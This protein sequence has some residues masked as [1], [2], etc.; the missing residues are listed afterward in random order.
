MHLNS[1]CLPHKG[2]KSLMNGAWLDTKQNHCKW[3]PL[4]ALYLI[5]KVI[6]LLPS[7]VACTLTACTILYPVRQWGVNTEGSE[8]VAVTGWLTSN[9]F[10][11]SEKL[12]VIVV[13][14]NC[15]WLHTH[16]PN[17]S[18]SSVIV[19]NHNWSVPNHNWS[20]LAKFSE[21]TKGIHHYSKHH[22]DF[23]WTDS[24]FNLGCIILWSIVTVYITVAL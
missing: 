18:L 14:K 23:K 8:C 9:S 20:E 19:P 22:N 3:Q 24:I 10:L 16:L 11:A 12:I 1:C 21:F 6:S 7:L 4:D 5:I 17:Q 15:L 13:N 2:V